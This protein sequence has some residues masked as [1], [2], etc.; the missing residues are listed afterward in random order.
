ML[1]FTYVFPIY[2]IREVIT[3][4]LFIIVLIDFYRHNLNQLKTLSKYTKYGLR[5]ITIANILAYTIMG[6]IALFT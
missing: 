3:F 6:V 2:W 4:A 5:V 1:V